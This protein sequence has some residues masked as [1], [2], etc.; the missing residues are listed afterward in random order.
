MNPQKSQKFPRLGKALALIESLGNQLPD[1]L[2]IF[3]LLS[4]MVILVS[5]IAA[6]FNVS[7]VHPG[8]KETIVA[9]SL[10]TPDGIRRIFTSAV[11]NFTDFP[12]LG[13]VLVAMLG[14][15]VAEY[16]G[17]LS[18]LLRK[19]VL[20]APRKFICPVVVFA[21]IMANIAADAGY[22]VL[23][24]MGAIIFL[25][26]RRHPLAGLAAAFA[27]VSGGFSA[28]LL[29]SSLDPLLAG[30]T[31]SAVQLINPNYS[32]NATANYY[33][34]VFSTLLITIMG[35]FVTEKIVE[36]RL[37]NYV[38]EVDFEMQQM[39]PGEHKG[40]RWAGY[41]LLAFIFCLLV[42]LLPPQG[43]L[44]HPETL[45]IIPSPFLDS[46]VFIIALAF[47]IPGIFYGKVTG[48]IQNHQDI[49]KALSNSMSAMGYYIVLAFIAAQFIAY[50]S[51]SNLGVIMSINGA[52]LLKS[53]GITGVPLLIL[54]ILVTMVLNLF[55]GSASAKWAIMAPVFV[56]MLMLMGYSPELTQ[57]A[58]RI[59]DSTTNIV[60]PLMPY[61]PLVVAFGQKYDK[62]LGL[63]TLIA[64]MLPYA[65]TFLLGWSL[66]LIIWFIFNLPLGPGALMRI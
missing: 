57:A 65:I 66:L 51:W 6:A 38:G 52:E 11:K 59:G 7:V 43:I 56:P 26:F 17:L 39:S 24:P 33:F 20:I 31:Q 40:L 32:V 23:I 28:N 4:L 42:M 62:N 55:V 10:L 30:L 22:V 47:L 53:T 63:G 64:M 5:T 46:I 1:P 58:Y 61:F 60:T 37:G 16:T 8:N 13:A 18:A 41:S 9:V 50:F 36:P 25:A 14:V 35:W 21:G 44:R 27:G 49:A 3:F 12:P 19:I 2:T 15:G 54:F 48:S 45:T 29:I 34:M